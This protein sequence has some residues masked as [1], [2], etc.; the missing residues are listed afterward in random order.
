MG[1]RVSAPAI[2][3]ALA[4]ELRA[5]VLALLNAFDERAIDDPRAVLAIFD[6]EH[7]SG[8]D[9]PLAPWVLVIDA[10]LDEIDRWIEWGAHD[11]ALRGATDETLQERLR[12]A[13][14]V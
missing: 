12:V 7:A 13:T 2:A 3:L 8:R 10:Q 9:A 11:C 1:C 6:P 14:K 5:R 4:P